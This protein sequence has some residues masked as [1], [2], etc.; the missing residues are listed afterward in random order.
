MTTCVVFYYIQLSSFVASNVHP[1]MELSN[2]I[3]TATKL[4]LG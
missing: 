3:C 1:P 4:I 2:K